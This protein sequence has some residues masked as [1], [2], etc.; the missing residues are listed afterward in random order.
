MLPTGISEGE[1][2]VRAA[3]SHTVM[4][5][6]PSQRRH[7][8]HQAVARADKAAHHVRG[9]EVHEA[10][11]ARERHRDVPVSAATSTIKHAI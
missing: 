8:Q 7:G 9:D 5:A 1:A 11:D 2:S 4:N 10:D 3:R 6:P